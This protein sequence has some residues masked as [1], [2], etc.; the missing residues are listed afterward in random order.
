MPF[1]KLLPKPE[2]KSEAEEADWVS[3]IT[4]DKENRVD[5]SDEIFSAYRSLLEK[6]CKPG[7]DKQHGS[8]TDCDIPALRAIAERIHY[9]SMYVAE[10]KFRG[11][12]EKI[13]ALIKARDESGLR[14][15][16]T[17]EC[18]EKEIY[19]RV[20]QKVIDFQKDVNPEARHLIDPEVVV[21]FYMNVI[22]P[23]T[24][25]GEVQ[26]LLQKKV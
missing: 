22:I 11:E 1:S 13:T 7:D 18:K 16:V 25:K 15:A 9:G 10:C 24:K 17:R 26:Y 6:I 23:L 8:C 21:E 14:K 3:G 4:L 12:P 19:E 2:R 20:R 5:L